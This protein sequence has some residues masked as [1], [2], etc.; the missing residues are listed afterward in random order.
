MDASEGTLIDNQVLMSTTKAYNLGDP[1]IPTATDLGPLISNPTMGV[2]GSVVRLANNNSVIGMRIDA[3]NAAGTIF[4]NGVSNA[5]PITDTNITCNIFTNYDIGANLQDVTGRVIVDQNEFN[6]LIGASNHGLDL[7]I[8]GGSTS[9]L[10]IRDNSASNNSGVGLNVIAKNGSTINADNP[11]GAYPTGILNNTASDN[12]TGIA[13]EAQSGATINAV[14][15][16]NTASDNTL[17]GLRATSDN[18]IFNL[19]SLEGNTFNQ[20]LNNGTF[21]HYLNGGV[22]RSVSEDLN[23]N[24]VLDP[25]EDLNGNLKMDSGIVSNTMDGNSIAGLFIFGEDASTGVFDIGGPTPSLGNTFRGN[26]EG[27]ILTDLRDSAT[28]Q[29]DALFNTI[30]GGTSTPG[31]TIVLDF[32]DPGQAPEVDA[33]GRLVNAF[34]V[35]PYGFSNAQYDQVTNAVLQTV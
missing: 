32:I 7:S 23:G 6:G 18:G 26:A 12:G 27:G 30:E 16:G 34:D 2:G 4:G 19:A 8:A 22:F 10:L 21:I 17:D 25:G 1:G 33:N 9:N 28:A 35:T 5:L 14:V 24:G 13:M 29:I 31:L 20:N 3:S 11:N 15:E